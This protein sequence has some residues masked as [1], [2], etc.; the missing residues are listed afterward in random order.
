M[1]PPLKPI[2]IQLYSLR[3]EAAQDFPAVLR[4][5][6]EIGYKGVEPAGF[7]GFAPADFRRF[8]EDLGMVVSS[9]HSPWAGPNNI[10]EVIDVCGTLGVN[11]TAGGYGSDA[12]A[13]LDA[14]KK[15][16]ETTQVIHDQLAAAGL[17]LTLH[18]HAWEF[19]RL[20]GR[21]K[22]E[23]F[24]ELCPDVSFELDT[25]W[26][27][28][29]GENSAPEMV[30]QFGSRSPLLH[31]KDGP[32]VRPK[33]TY[34]AETDVMEIDRSVSTSL[35]PVG[36]GKN[37]IQGIIAAM[38]PSVTQWLVVEQ[39]NSDTDMM[40]CVEESYRYLISNGLASGN[41]PA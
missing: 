36:S 37:D 7:F 33:T 10:A 34:N 6:A 22:Y 24:A 28:N 38:D 14:I 12:F 18:N 19:E 30:R 31:I 40:T 17:T 23:I 32:M 16:A 29:F 8:V 25:Y 35:L 4:R 9:T 21:L 26:A 3:A 39:D 13:T 41:K 2:S 1:N 11:L 27:A 15:T 5:L 20:D